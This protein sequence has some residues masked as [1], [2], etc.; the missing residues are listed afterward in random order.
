MTDQ[1][2]LATAHL[3]GATDNRDLLTGPH[4][5]LVDAWF[6][7]VPGAEIAGDVAALLG[8]V[9]RHRR[10]TSGHS[11]SFLILRLDERGVPVETLRRANL[12]VTKFGLHEHRITLGPDWAPD[13]LRGDLRWI[14][15]ACTSPDSFDG[16]AGG[17]VHLCPPRHGGAGRPVLWLPL[18]A[19][20]PTARAARRAPSG[21]PPLRPAGDTLHVVLPTGTGK[22]LVGIAPGL[23]ARTGVTVVVVPTIA[24][25]L[26]QERQLHQRFP[27]QGLPQRIGLLRRPCGD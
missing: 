3:A 26:D 23:L 27:N 1:W 5:R 2:N 7:E 19:S 15:L 25:A 4:R 9:L 16:P 12:D 21:R 8:Q 22:S 20:T 11:N 6:S 17:R 13:W 10:G 18:L 14:D 24:L